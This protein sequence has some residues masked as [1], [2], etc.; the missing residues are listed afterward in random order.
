MP[1]TW[2]CGKTVAL[3][4]EKTLAGMDEDSAAEAASVETRLPK[5]YRTSRERMEAASER[6]SVEAKDWAEMARLKKDD[7]PPS[8]Y[9]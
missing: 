2:L 6:E 1:N 8:G 7:R 4:V 5:S 3:V 9:A